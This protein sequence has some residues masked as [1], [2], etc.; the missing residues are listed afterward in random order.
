MRIGLA[1]PPRTLNIWLASDANSNKVLSQIYQPLYVL[2]PDTLEPVPWLAAAM[3]RFDAADNTYTVALR[4]A[5]WSD[6]TPL[7]AADVA[8]TGRLIQTFNIPRYAAKWAPVADIE[9]VDA[10]TVVFR[11]ERPCANFIDGALTT[12][13]VP[14]HQWGPAAE[15]AHRSAKPLAALLNH[16]IGTPIGSGP[17][18]LAGY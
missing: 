13:V 14:A 8:F 15:A 17:F 12:P 11:L 10:Q 2:A 9:A 7:T 5:R 18:M 3:P 4:P 6:G 16:A 1:E